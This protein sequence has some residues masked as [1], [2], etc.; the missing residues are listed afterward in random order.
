MDDAW[1]EGDWEAHDSRP[2]TSE[3]LCPSF[4]FAS[5]IWP[6]AFINM[7]PSIHSSMVSSTS[8]AK[9]WTCLMSAD[10]ISLVRGDV[11]GPMALMTLLVKLGSN[12]PAIFAMLLWLF[13]E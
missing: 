4:R 6:T 8:R 5:E 7:T 13:G 1:V 11:L 2:M 10:M 12:L 3:I 9:S